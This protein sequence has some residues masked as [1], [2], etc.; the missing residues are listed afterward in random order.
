MRVIRTKQVV[1]LR[2]ED[3]IHGVIEKC[4]ELPCLTNYMPQI[5]RFNTISTK[6]RQNC[7]LPISHCGISGFREDTYYMNTFLKIVN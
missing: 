7:L 1:P 6:S 5:C 3:A 2:N 4:F